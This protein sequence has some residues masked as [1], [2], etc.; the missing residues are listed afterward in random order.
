MRKVP[1]CRFIV[2][3]D[4]IGAK[5]GGAEIHKFQFFAVLNE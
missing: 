3:D 2:N 4:L 5:A 1:L